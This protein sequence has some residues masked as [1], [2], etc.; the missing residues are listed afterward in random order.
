MGFKTLTLVFE[1]NAGFAG[2]NPN[3]PKATFLI[4]QR[5]PKPSDSSDVEWTERMR[6]H[7]LRKPRLLSIQL[8]GVWGCLSSE[9]WTL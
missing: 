7:T 4:E 3:A 6:P 2:T 8:L 1:L 5:P 9:I